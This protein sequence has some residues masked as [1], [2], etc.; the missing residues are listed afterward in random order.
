ME[1]RKGL[2][3]ARTVT[4]AVIAPAVVPFMYFLVMRFASGFTAQGSGHT[5]KLL[6][7]T[8]K[9]ILI[10]S[11]AF[12]YVFGTIIFFLLNNTGRLQFFP[13]FASSAASGALIGLFVVARAIPISTWT[14]SE[15]VA[16][17]LAFC[18][19]FCNCRVSHLF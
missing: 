9:G 5:E 3:R 16:A 19:P 1:F 15:A 2:N 11:Y 8:L 17:L 14:A 10:P 4:A 18:L 13:C 7:V 12:S 6:D